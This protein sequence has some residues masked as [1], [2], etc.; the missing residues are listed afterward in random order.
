MA[1]FIYDN[2]GQKVGN[3]EIDLD[4]DVLK[5]CLLT[6]T[7][8]PDQT[9][10][11]YGDLDNEVV[12]DG[13]TIG[14]ETLTT[15]SWTTSAGVATSDADDPTWTTA[16][17]TARY[18]VIYDDTVASDPLICLY[19]FGEDKTVNYGTFTLYFNAN[20]ILRFRHETA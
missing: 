16:T 3:K 4:N 5:V 18:A 8:T 15:V 9:H 20:G 11:F 17:F 7:H 10:E 14:G 12:G 13:Y 19:D 2:F 6:S 1:N